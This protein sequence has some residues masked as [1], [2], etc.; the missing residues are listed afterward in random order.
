VEVSNASSL[1]QALSLSIWYTLQIMNLIIISFI[2]FLFTSP[3][4]KLRFNSLIKHA[5]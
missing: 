4:L 5:L 1:H 2:R 3:A